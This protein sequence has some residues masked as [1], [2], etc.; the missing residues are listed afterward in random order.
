VGQ[1]STAAH[2]GGVGLGVFKQGHIKAG[3]KVTSVENGS[4]GFLAEDTGSLL[5]AGACCRSD[6]NHESGFMASAHA[7]LQAGDSCSASSN[8][9]YGLV[10][11]DGGQL[12]VGKDSKAAGN[13][14]GGFAAVGHNAKLL[15]KPGCTSQGNVCDDEVQDWV[16]QEGGSLVAVP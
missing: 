7:Q 6:H 8:W 14:V 9:E 4:H 2:N 3:D 15:H 5:E 16:E 13:Y 11:A 10:A 1:G 12:T